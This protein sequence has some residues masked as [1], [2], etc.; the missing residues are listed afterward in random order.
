MGLG[1]TVAA[2]GASQARTKYTSDL[3]T[4]VGFYHNELCTALVAQMQAHGQGHTQA[5]TAPGFGYDAATSYG[6]A[7]CWRDFGLAVSVRFA[8]LLSCAICHP[9]SAHVSHTLPL[10]CITGTDT[11]VI[12]TR[13]V[14][15]R[16]NAGADATGTCR[17][18]SG[19]NRR[20]RWRTGPR[21]DRERSA[22][23]GGAGVQNLRAR[24]G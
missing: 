24:A 19:S 3:R 16:I 6:E 10:Y 4:I 13:C 8:T 23:A 2:A 22:Y 7:Q 11:C 15:D 21:H 1:A 5:S 18:R 9:R 14:Q 12:T 20:K 17:C